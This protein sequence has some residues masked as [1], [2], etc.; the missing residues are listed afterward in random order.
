MIYTPRKK[1]NKN[2]YYVKQ[3]IAKAKI[4]LMFINK[5]SSRKSSYFRYFNSSI[6]RKFL[7]A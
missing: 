3:P 5:T 4:Y 1:Y 7:L 6:G 2:I